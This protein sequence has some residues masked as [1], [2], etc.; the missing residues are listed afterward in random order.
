MNRIQ[1]VS[2]KSWQIDAAKMFMSLSKNDK[3][4]ILSPRQCGKS[5]MITQFLLST[6]INKPKTNSICIS[7]VNRQ[8]AKL[9]DL[10]KSMVVKS[11]LVK[12]ANE[13]KMEI[14]FIN[15]STILFLSAESGDNIRGNT[16]SGI[17]VVDEAVF[18]KDSMWA[19]ILPFVNVSRAPVILSSTPRQKSG[20]FF[21]C[22]SKVMSHEQNYHGLNAGSYDLSW[23]R[24]EEMME[25]FKRTLSPGFYKSEILGE[26][27]DDSEGVFGDFASVTQEPDNYDVV[28]A[29]IDWSTVG[30][31]STQL[32][33]WNA[34]H[35]MTHIKSFNRKDPMEVVDSLASFLNSHPELRSVQ[36]ESNS[37]G[38]VFFSA[39]KRKLKNPQVL[40]KFNTS[41]SSKKAIV[42]RM[43][44]AISKHEVT[45]LPNE[46][47]RFQF[48]NFEVKML[49]SGNY[50]YGNSS[51]NVHDDLVMASCIGADLFLKNSTYN[52]L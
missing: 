31:D 21:N 28:F 9:F 29:G 47:L 40:K 35:Q 51:D 18:I 49:P 43:V 3:M 33:C 50:T 10:M 52:I 38:E 34:K 23:F 46:D 14:K 4:V 26:F 1:G 42:E 20:Y 2:L 48:M 19:V 22:W 30:T 8:N 45:L 16:V 44:E 7:P 25:D 15:G 5:L 32:V 12:S 41:N 24:S 17:L 36:V 27:M 37:I 39:L 11:P 6:A 13:S